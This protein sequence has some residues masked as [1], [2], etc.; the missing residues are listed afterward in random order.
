MW[1]S[2]GGG[3]RPSLS[4]GYSRD[5]LAQLSL[6]RPDTENAI[7]AA[8][9]SSGTRVVEGTDSSTG[10]VVVPVI[11]PD[12]CAGVLALE[13]RERGERHESG[14]ALATILAAQL[15]ILAEAPTV[16]RAATA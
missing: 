13:F 10:A 2:K 5:I 9:R 8:F 3:L 12:G 15:S 4:H 16:M 14:H 6:V 7:A 1:D 11:T